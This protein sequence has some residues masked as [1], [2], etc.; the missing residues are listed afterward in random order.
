M[1]LKMGAWQGGHLPLLS[2]YDHAQR[3]ELIPKKDV[4]A[5]LISSTAN[6]KCPVHSKSHR[7]EEL[8]EFSLELLRD[9]MKKAK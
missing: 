2:N 7:L 3:G 9:L 8:A 5:L 4:R 6:D 1:Y